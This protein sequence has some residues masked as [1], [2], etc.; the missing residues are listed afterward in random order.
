MLPAVATAVLLPALAA[1]GDAPVPGP[2]VAGVSAAPPPVDAR[3]ELAARA[4]AAADRTFAARYTLTGQGRPQRTVIVVKAADGTWRVD[5]PAGA[6]GGTADISIG[7]IGNGIFTCT[8]PSA[9]RPVGSTCVKVADKASKVPAKL[10]PQ[11][12]HLFSDWISV[13]T[14]QQAPLSVSVASPLPGAQ[15]TC[16]AIES[17]SAQ[18]G[19][20]LDPGI[21]CFAEDGLLTAARVS[22][23]T[24]VLVGG[25]APG[26]PSVSLPGAVVAGEPLKMASPPPPPTPSSS[27]APSAAAG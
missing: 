14:D 23:G 17:T 25:A 13:L 3:F 16:F 10:D 4:A 24:L 11:V 12:Q 6:A 18:I 26:P 19:A 7:R 22:F 20:P 15:G 27:A 1:C 2:P 5:I 21:Y 8:L 9:T